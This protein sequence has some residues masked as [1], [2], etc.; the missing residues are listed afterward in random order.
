MITHLKKLSILAVILTAATLF[1]ID[2]AEAQLVLVESKYR[3]VE[4]DQFENR[5]GVALPDANPNEVQT[6]VYVKSDTRASK[7]NYTGNGYYRDEQLTPNGVLNAA[8][9][10]EGELIKVHGGRDFDGSID[11]KAIWM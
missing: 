2:A 10:R 3:I 5:I 6:W 1:G 4:V 11:A 9:R 8:E 7:R